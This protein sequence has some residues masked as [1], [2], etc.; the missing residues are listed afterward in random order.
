MDS[1]D[2]WHKLPNRVP[3][4]TG[5]VAHGHGNSPSLVRVVLN[6]LR[7]RATHDFLCDANRFRRE[8]KRTVLAAETG[9]SEVAPESGRVGNLVGPEV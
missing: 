5:D 3:H 2:R 7:Q 4:V 8:P 6:A 9:E 1:S